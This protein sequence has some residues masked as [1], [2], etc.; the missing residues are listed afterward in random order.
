ME[1][2]LKITLLDSAEEFRLRLEGKLSGPWVFEL[3]QCWETA[4][5]TTA[6]R[7]TVVDLRDVDYVDQAGELLLAD[8][9]RR[10]VELVA[11]TP[12]IRTVVEECV[13]RCDRVE[14]KPARSIHAFFCPDPS[15]PNSPAL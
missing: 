12:L 7:R 6:G 10:E 9:H 14:E 15:G 3:R 8:M 1:V 11:V 13:L 2:M 4:C 5:S